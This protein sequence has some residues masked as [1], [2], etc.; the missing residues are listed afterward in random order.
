MDFFKFLL[1]HVAGVS[2]S[3]L[4][5]FDALGKIANTLLDVFQR[6]A[7]QAVA[8]RGLICTKVWASKMKKTGLNRPLNNQAGL[9]G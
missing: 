8:D 4:T 9:M 2:V 5:I 7:V 3:H 1:I 6:L